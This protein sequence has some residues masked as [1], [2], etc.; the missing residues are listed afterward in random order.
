MSKTTHLFEEKVYLIS[1]HAVALNPMFI[2]ESMQKYFLEK[3]KIYL[4]PICNVLAYSLEDHEYQLLVKLKK[5]EDFVA[6]YLEKNR[7]FLEEQDEVPP[8]TYIFSQSMAN[9]QVSFVKH[10][11]FINDR[12]GTLMASRFSRKLVETPEEMNRWKEKLNEGIKKHNYSKEWINQMGRSEVKY[13]SEWMYR[14]SSGSVGSG[15][16]G[17]FYQRTDNFDLGVNWEKSK[18]YKLDSPFP[19]FKMHLNRLFHKNGHART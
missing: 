2:D 17:G 14:K 9:M 7:N 18:K 8:S 11:N 15:V 13:T 1:N 5:K 12:S 16:L 10:F 19:F 3:M 4:E 6:L